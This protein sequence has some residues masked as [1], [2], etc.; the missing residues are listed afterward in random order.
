MLCHGSVLGCFSRAVCVGQLYW[1][2]LLMW[3]GRRLLLL[4]LSLRQ[5]Q[6]QPALCGRAALLLL[7]RKGQ[8]C[9]CEA[10][11]LSVAAVCCI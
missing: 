11:L 3:S 5:Q 10:M 4:L 7:L 9:G 1:G 6:P 8:G 2:V